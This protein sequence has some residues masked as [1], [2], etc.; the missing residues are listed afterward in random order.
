M[1]GIH[2][3]GGREGFGPVEHDGGSAP[4][5]KRWEW[6]VFAM[7]RATARAGARRST[8]Q[9]RHAVERI[10]PFAYLTHGYYG[11][12][13]GGVENLLIEAG[14]TSA[15]EIDQLQRSE[16]RS[17]AAAPGEALP[18]HS[19]PAGTRRD[20]SG[21]SERTISA[22][23]AFQV[24][25]HIL[26]ARHGA[27]GH[28]RLPAYARGR[29]GRITADHGGWIFPD[30]NAHHLGEDPQRLYSIS[31]AGEELWGPSAEPGVTVSL[32]LF[33]PYVDLDSSP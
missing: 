13:L 31:F 11:R 4:P 10:A 6:A 19:G 21:E 5:L 18:A 1:D 32:D 2:D 7:V 30:S 9:F 27:P 24:G 8:D 20:A 28:T 16:P 29:R 14:V 12:W 22:P 3:L 25:D 33:E 17:V 26:T 23:A 15:D